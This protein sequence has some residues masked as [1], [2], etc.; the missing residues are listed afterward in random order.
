MIISDLRNYF[1]LQVKAIDPDIEGFKDDVFGNNDN[2]KNKADKYYNLSIGDL[3]STKDGNGLDD[4]FSLTLDV[5]TSSKTKV[6]NS[7]DTLYEKAILIR[8]KVVCPK[9]Y[10]GIFSD[11][12][13]DSITPEEE[14]TNDK[15]IKMR[16]QLQ[17]RVAYNFN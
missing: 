9:N 1:D 2:Y 4:V 5:F 8:D 7:F 3:N 15:Y 10:N 12:I 13:C 6:Q 16:L 11:V 14:L 17:V